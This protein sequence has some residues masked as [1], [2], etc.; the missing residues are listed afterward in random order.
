MIE[1]L[2][3]SKNFGSLAAVK[4]VS[5]SVGKGEVFGLLGPNGAGKT[6]TIRM[7]TTL[8]QPSSGTALVAGHDILADPLAVKRA[9]GVIPQ[10]L[11]LDIDLTLAENLEYHGRLHRMERLDRTSRTDELLKFVGLWEKRDTPVEHLSGGMRRRLLI[12]RGLMHRPQ[13]VFMDEPTVGL[14]PQARHL[15][16]EMIEDLKQSGITILLTTHYIEEAD[17]LCDRVAIMQQGKVVTLGA[18][19]DLKALVGRYV[20]ECHGRH[21]LR[22]QFRWTRDEALDAGKGMGCNVTVRDVTLEDVFIEL[23]G[24][25]IDA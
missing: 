18:P 22:R 20:A 4:S 25:R 8:T 21:D 3:L 6:T 2:N 17:R 11:N 15:I 19:A 13:V 9:I 1:L 7:L 5:F 23:T 16:W 12:A 10:L 14:D 24:E